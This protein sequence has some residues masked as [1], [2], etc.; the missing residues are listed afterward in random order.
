MHCS[1][2]QYFLY[3]HVGFL[4]DTSQCFSCGLI[5]SC[6][7]WNLDGFHH[8]MYAT[9]IFIIDQDPKWLYN[10]GCVKLFSFVFHLLNSRQNSLKYVDVLTMANNVY[11]CS[12]K[13]G[14][15]VL[16]LESWIFEEFWEFHKLSFWCHNPNQNVQSSLCMYGF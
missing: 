3:G 16:Q 8:N 6:G 14:L 2:E 12:Y 11:T 4:A 13:N 1:G 5:L 15:K 7:I 9:D 10:F